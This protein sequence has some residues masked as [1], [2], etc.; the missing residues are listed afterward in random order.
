MLAVALDEA[1][2]SGLWFS[3]SVLT[4]G[5]KSDSTECEISRRGSR[6]KIGEAVQAVGTIRLGVWV[7]TMA[8]RTSGDRYNT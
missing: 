5:R 3:S 6:K 1:S 2:R 8:A 4:A 7:D